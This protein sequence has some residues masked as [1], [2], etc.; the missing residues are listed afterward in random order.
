MTWVEK[1]LKLANLGHKARNK[2]LVKIVE[3]LSAAPGKSIPQ[4]CK[5]EAEMRGIYDFWKNPRVKARDILAAHTASTIERVKECETVLSVQDTTD[6]DFS[7]HRKKR[8]MGYLDKPKAKGMK[9]HTS[10]CVTTDGVPLGVL[11]QKTWARPAVKTR[12]PDPQRSIQE[13]ESYRWLETQKIVEELVP[14]NIRVVTV[15]DREADIYELFAQPRRPGAELL[16]RAYHER[17]VKTQE[18]H[19]EILTISQAIGQVK[20]CGK[21]TLELKRTPRRKPRKATITV[22]Y[23]QLEIQPPYGKNLEPISINVIL[24]EEENPPF[25][26]KPVRW[27]LLTTLPV[28]TFED[29]R[30]Y[31]EWYSYRWLVE[32]YH[33]TLKSGCQIEKLQLESLDRIER[34]LATYDIV[35]WRL[36]WLTYQARCHPNDDGGDIVTAEQ[37]QVLYSLTHNSSE[38]P[39]GAPTVEQCVNAIAKLG[40][41]LGRKIDGFPGVKVLW[42]GLEQLNIYVR[43]WR[44]AIDIA[45]T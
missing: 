2:R 12:E 26:K 23:A 33:Y 16:I 10:L 30:Q 39:K 42:R 28:E 37:W 22:R 43:G 32:R 34:A 31:L 13:K 4:L 17:V 3:T 7:K 18:S 6:L 35:A 21:I 29:A 14:E 45:M 38:E 24:A 1:E 40:G 20:P 15:A 41:F 44:L 5:T 36:L 11:A 27:L 8:N 25:N 19:D 9:V